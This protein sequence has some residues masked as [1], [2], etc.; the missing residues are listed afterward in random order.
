MHNMNDTVPSGQY[1]F[2]IENPSGAM[3]TRQTDALLLQRADLYTNVHKGIRALMCDTL[4]KLGKTDCGDAVEFAQTLK[5]LRE[6]IAICEVH[7]D[8]E[9]NFIHP[10]M[11]AKQPG[12]EQTTHQEHIQHRSALNKLRD[13]V[14]ALE[15]AWAPARQELAGRLYQQLALI[16]AENFV[17]M[18]VEE[19]ENAP[20]LRR[21]YSTA[22]LAAI[23]GKLIASIPADTAALSLSWMIPAMTPEDRA[24]MLH[25]MRQAMPAEKFLAVLNSVKSRLSERDREKLMASF[26]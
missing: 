8:V 10:A 11:A 3:N 20:V 4:V 16:I 14:N 2:D 24:T 18:H 15:R 21:A 6:L 22:E 13:D 7:A 19:T 17:H 26:A 25:G 5:Q 9:D 23:Q 12:S 1:E